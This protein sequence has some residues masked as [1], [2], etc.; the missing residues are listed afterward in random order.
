MKSISIVLPFAVLGFILSLSVSL[1]Q[2]LEGDVESGK[3]LYYA[4]RC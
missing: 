3:K 2:E 1:A 4:Y